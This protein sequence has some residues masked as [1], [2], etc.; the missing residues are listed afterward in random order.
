[1]HM[2]ETS[3]HEV[4]YDII[5]AVCAERLRLAK[6]HARTR[7][8]ASVISRSLVRSRK[9]RCRDGQVFHIQQCHTRDV[10]KQAL[11]VWGEKCLL[12]Y[13]MP[14]ALS[15]GFACMVTPIFAI[16]SMAKPPF[17]PPHQWGH[18]GYQNWIRTTSP[19]CAVFFSETAISLVL[20][21]V[22]PTAVCGE[23]SWEVVAR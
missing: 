20:H 13:L 4:S 10:S 18:Y 12:Q 6:N 3:S 5:V 7:T 8:A 16:A 23:C 1:M 22:F 19:A 14:S 2:H 11:G 17:S 21:T 15:L 9:H